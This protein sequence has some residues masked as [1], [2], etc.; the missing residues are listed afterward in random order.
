M[1]YA[2][3]NDMRHEASPKQKGLCVFCQQPVLAKCGTHKVWHWA[4]TRKDP[5]LDTWHEPETKWHRDWKNLFSADWQEY[6]QHDQTGERHIAD[7][8]TRHGLVIEFQYSHLKPEEQTS[9]ETFYGNMIWVVNGNRLKR[10][11]PRAL[12]GISLCQSIGN[13]FFLTAYPQKC[14]HKNWLACKSPVFF[15]FKDI[16]GAIVSDQFREDLWCLWPG[17]ADGQAVIVRVNRDAFIAAASSGV[18]IFGQPLDS[19]L[20][21]ISDA[22]QA[23]RQAIRRQQDAAFLKTLEHKR[24]HWPRRTARF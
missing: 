3:M 20:A 23:H 14:F 13:G 22:L 6:I 8:R 18:D 7:I 9:R 4:H 24:R 2:L 5:C 12:E 11:Y 19:L 16:E 21:Q 1:R 15:D 10:D 17:R